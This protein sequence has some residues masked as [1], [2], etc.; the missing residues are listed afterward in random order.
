MTEGHEY[1]D[2]EQYLRS[3]HEVVKPLLPDGMGY[4]LFMFHFG[5]ADMIK[6]LGG[7]MVWVSNAQ[8]ADMIKALG[9]WIAHE[10]S[11]A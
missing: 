4:G 2:L 5:D 10:R 3:I 11:K 9:E 1:P 6:S 7:A 8:R